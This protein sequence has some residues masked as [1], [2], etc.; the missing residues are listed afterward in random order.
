MR[1]TPILKIENSNKFPSCDSKSLFSLVAIM[2]L[3]TFQ[4]K[5]QLLLLN[6]PV[7][8]CGHIFNHQICDSSFNLQTGGGGEERGGDDEEEEDVKSTEVIAE[9]NRGGQISAERLRSVRTAAICLSGN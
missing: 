6:Q 8:C 2:F 5:N 1:G 3:H 4:L 7:W 9:I